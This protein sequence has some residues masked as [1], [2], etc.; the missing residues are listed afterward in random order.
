MEQSNSYSMISIVDL[1]AYLISKFWILL[2][3]ALIVA[4]LLFSSSVFFDNSS[5]PSAEKALKNL[6][7]LLEIMD[8]TT[9]TGPVFV[10][11]DTY[12]SRYVFVIDY[13]NEKAKVE[14]NEDNTVTI[15][16]SLGIELEKYWNSLNVSSLVGSDKDNDYL[17][18]NMYFSVDGFMVEG[19]V[20]SDKEGETI[21]YAEKISDAISSF[22]N[23]H[24]TEYVA[25][26]TITTGLAST[27]DK[28]TFLEGFEKE[29]ISISREVAEISNQ[30]NS[31][32]RIVKKTVFGFL[33][34]GII[35]LLILTTGFVSRNPI[36]SSFSSERNLDLPFWGA[37]YKDYSFLS[38]L[39]RSVMGERSNKCHS[40]SIAFIRSSFSSKLISNTET[41]KSITVLS[42]VPEKQTV[43]ASSEICT[44][45]KECGFNTKFVGN[46]INN[47][48]TIAAIENTDAVLLLEEQWNSRLLY[49]KSII[50]RT[51][52]LGKKTIGFV[53]C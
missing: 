6:N 43:F 37:C 47:P 52:L 14:K 50:N 53:L 26:K 46:A 40:D 17:K 27:T 29:R 45:L 15:T 31:K 5:N 38:R 34:G 33:V 48:Q 10:S 44:L 39:S 24:T 32:S 28:K 1:F 25:F 49:V 2:I 7:K 11:E 36:T 22:I 13:M 20:F 35:S 9:K 4:V 12:C 23:S 21:E 16:T 41:I 18:M 51:A 3:S 8:E 19:M 30:L 42:S